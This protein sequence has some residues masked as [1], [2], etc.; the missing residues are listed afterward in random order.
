M[1]AHEILQPTQPR[2][3]DIV[4]FETDPTTVVEGV[5]VGET[6]DGYIYEFSSS[7]YTE[8]HESCTYGKYYCSTDKVYKCRKGPKQTRTVESVRQS[9]A[10][11]YIAIGPNRIKT[12]T[13]GPDAGKVVKDPESLQDMST[14]DFFQKYPDLRQSW[15]QAYKQYIIGRTPSARAAV[16]AEVDKKLNDYSWMTPE[17]KAE[18]ERLQALDTGKDTHTKS[19]KAEKYLKQLFQKKTDA[20]KTASMLKVHWAPLS[21]LPKYLKGQVSPKIELSAYLAASPQD[22]GKQRWGANTVGIVLDG[23]ITMAGRGDLGSDQYKMTAGQ[24]GQQKYT[25][26][27]GQIDPSFSSID[28]GTHHE[29]LVDNW[30]IREIVL[31]A[32]IPQNIDNVIKKYGIPVRRLQATQGVAESWSKKYK[33]SINCSHPKGFSQKAHCAGKKKHNESVEMEMTCEDCGMCQAHGSLNEIK[34]GQ[35][36]AN[37]NTRCWHGKHAEGTKKGKNGGQVR[38]CV[39]NESFTALEMAI[40]EG[41][42]SLEEAE[43]HGRKVQLGKPTRGDVK[44]FKVYVRDPK[45]GNIKKVNFGDPNMKIKKN[46]PARRKSF[47]ARHKCDTAK[48]RTTARYWSCRKW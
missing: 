38:N 2:I 30:K 14:D 35:K 29:V 39:P 45:T 40:M 6:E 47:R 22:L 8:L 26:R 28:L 34:K 44:K 46:I 48:D 9:V 32:D 31:P 27:P 25:S 13:S 36:D 23:H 37:G 19:Y 16:K 33:D 7:G 43:Y 15:E 24:R 4:E 10:E 41:G 5:I 12:L 1:R 42:H 3:G 18:Y 20:K 17:E 11:G 21:D